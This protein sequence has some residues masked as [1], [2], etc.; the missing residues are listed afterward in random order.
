MKKMTALVLALALCL[1]LA[2]CGTDSASSTTAPQNTT[3]TSTETTAISGGSENTA[4]TVKVDPST[5]DA[6]AITVMSGGAAWSQFERG[7]FDACDELG[8]NGYYL[9]PV[10]RGNA[11]QMAELLDSAV[12]AGGDIIM[13]TF[14]SLDMF[15]PALLKSKENGAVNASVQVT[16]SEEYCD[17]QIG[18]DQE[19]IGVVWADTLIEY[20]EKSGFETLN[21]IL[22]RG[23]ASELSVAKD[24]AL[25]SR[26]EEKGYA[27]RIIYLEEVFDA[28][29]AVTAA[30]QYAD[31]YKVYPDLN[32]ILCE[33]SSAAT[34]G[35]ANFVQENHLED[36][37]ITIG[38]DASADILNYVLD[39]ALDCTINQDFYY[40]GYQGVKMA[41]DL[42]VNG[43]APA[44]YQNDSGC[45]L[46][47][48][49][50]V[51]EYAANAGIDLG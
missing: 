11:T 21:F 20:Y 35:A 9:A 30:E 22:G 7:F 3:E 49:E 18:T 48:P 10:D 36:Q 31:Y 27:D 6:Y 13:G 37:F 51:V 43:K 12:T 44:S 40:M 19:A 24:A 2:A 39:G 38:A 50:E 5:I 17:F 45:Y 26:L 29:S 33:N 16:L 41:Y 47:R 1:S 4:D 46:I 34:M 32:C 23:S 14:T 25:T 28:G 15:G 42:L 8:I